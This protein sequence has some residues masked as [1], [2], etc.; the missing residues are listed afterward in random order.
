MLAAHGPLIAAVQRHAGLFAS[1]AR[2]HPASS[3]PPALLAQAARAVG[4]VA[5]LIEMGKLGPQLALLQA[6]GPHLQAIQGALVAE[7]HQWNHWFY[8]S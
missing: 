7:P 6:A 4:G 1:L 5:N 2:Y 3:A 8:A